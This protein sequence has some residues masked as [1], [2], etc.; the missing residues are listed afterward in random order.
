MVIRVP[1]V[2][3]AAVGWAVA[4]LQ[5]GDPGCPRYPAAVRSEHQQSIELDREFQQYA[6]RARLASTN[7]P[8]PQADYSNFIDQVLFARMAA[9]GVVPA[10]RSSDSEFLRRVYLDL[11]GRI[12]SPEQAERFLGNVSIDKRQK[13]VDEL[14]ANSSYADQFALFFNN[15]F[16]ITRNHD[17][18]SVAAR[19]VFHE[20]L[21]NQM[22]TDRPYDA[23]VREMLAAS[24]EV[25]T[26]PGTQLFARWMDVDG[27][28]QDSWDDLTERITT[29]F[30]GYKT[31]CVSCHNGR[32]HLEKINLHLSKRTRREFWQMS[33]FLSRM[34]YLR[35]SDDPIGFRPR[36][37]LVD[38]DYGTYSGAVPVSNP[39]NRPARVGAVMT[40]EFFS[41]GEAPRTGAWR[42]ELGRMITSD[43]QFARATANH[44]WA[45]F[46]GYGIVDPPDAWDM[47]RVDPARPP[48]AEWPLQNSQPELLEKLADFFI[49]NQYRLKPLIRQIVLSETYQLSS[50]YTGVWKP[51][52]VKYFA[53]HEARRLSAEQMFDAIM[54]ATHTEVPIQL[55]SARRVVRYANQLPD[56][57]EP[58]TDFRI[59]DFLANL[60]RGN[61]TTVD[62]SSDPTL[63]GLLFQ[64][65]DGQNVFRSLG[66][67]GPNAPPQNRVHEIDAQAISDTEA[68]RRLWLATLTRYP[69][70]AE[71]AIV[72]QKKS[73]PRSQW[74][75]DLQWALLNKL[76]F[77]FQY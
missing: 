13:L 48:P 17:N 1:V 38:R 19:D 67:T 75:S 22:A 37:I 16:K 11:I 36:V 71:I 68:I 12:P 39:G 27:P 42:S 41:T 14:L 18:I 26:V 10:Q 62:R 2:G 57:T 52:Y 8:S 55:A 64:M 6:S 65:N 45:Y 46:F 50:A 25:D 73:G 49:Q 60:G 77:T 59:V 29:S 24:G 35:W 76:D 23:F 21:R 43:R 47:D 32:A 51:A 66:T 61:W 28:I 31:E 4:V 69:T 74:L 34:F 30:L 63:I 5:A 72:N 33:A 7:R 3:L 58:T 15:R 54:T 20:F 9:D 40:P 44:F 70:D 56:P 53:R